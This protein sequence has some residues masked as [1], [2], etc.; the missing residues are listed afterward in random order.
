[1]ML[2]ALSSTF[3][4]STCLYTFELYYTPKNVTSSTTRLSSPKDVLRDL[5]T[6]SNMESSR[7]DMRFTKISSFPADIQ[8]RLDPHWGFWI[9]HMV[10]LTKS[11][12]T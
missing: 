11:I 3:D 7:W 4:M 8:R 1:M 5:S 10:S 9:R 12:S 6:E 2:K